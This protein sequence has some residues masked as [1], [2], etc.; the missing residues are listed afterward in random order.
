MAYSRRKR[1]EA[2][3]IVAEIGRALSGKQMG[4]TNG[5]SA[6]KVLRQMGTRIR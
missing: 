3:L 2:R 6:A 1:F 4:G 5:K